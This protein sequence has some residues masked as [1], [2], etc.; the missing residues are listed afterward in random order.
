MQKHLAGVQH[1]CLRLENLERGIALTS[2]IILLSPTL[3]KSR[4][5][6]DY[7]LADVLG[8]SRHQSTRKLEFD[9]VYQQVEVLFGSQG[10]AT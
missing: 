6:M 4:S 1:P 9:A 5:K 2:I 10:T 7:L 3:V 8:H